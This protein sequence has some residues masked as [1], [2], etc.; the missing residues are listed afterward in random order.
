MDIRN[1]LFVVC[2]FLFVPVIKGQ[3]YTTAVGLRM[4]NDLGMTIQQRIA[5]EWTLE[6][7]VHSRFESED[8]AIHV[9]AEYHRPVLGRSLNM[10]FGVGP[11]LNYRYEITE[12]LDAGVSM[13]AGLELNLGKLNASLDIMP[14][15]NLGKA[16]RSFIPNSAFSIRY[17]LVKESKKYKR[18]WWTRKKKS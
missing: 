3:R 15:Y 18:K 16:E 7:I 13:V 1:L 6:G 17:V 2:A 10:Y 8:V 12:Q 11:Q 9:L 5:K 14:S 4:G